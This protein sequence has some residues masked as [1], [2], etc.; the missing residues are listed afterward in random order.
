M[1][2]ERGLLVCRALD[3]FEEEQM[4]VQELELWVETLC[5]ASPWTGREVLFMF[6]PDRAGALAGV[7]TLFFSSCRTTCICKRS[8]LLAGKNLTSPTLRSERIF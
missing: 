2:R 3:Q 1:T 6:L 8:F 4:Q 5:G 7:C